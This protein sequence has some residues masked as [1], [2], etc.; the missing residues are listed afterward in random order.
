MNFS[1]MKTKKVIG[2]IQLETPKTLIVDEFIALN[3][4]MS[5]FKCRDDSKKKLIG[6]SKTQSKH[7]K[8]KEYKNV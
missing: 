7:I 4:K 6:I 3:R 8:F 2:K 5:S 1:V